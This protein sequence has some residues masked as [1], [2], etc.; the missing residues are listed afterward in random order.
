[1]RAERPQAMKLSVI[2]LLICTSTIVHAA[3]KLPL[4]D[5]LRDV[6]NQLRN[7]GQQTDDGSM[8]VIIKNIHVDMH[9]IA[10]KNQ[11]GQTLY[12]VLEGMQDK[13]NVITQKI[14]FDLELR[15][16]Y[17]AAN[18]DKRY[19][20]YS[21]RKKDYR[22]GPDNYRPARPYPYRPEHYLPDLYP[23]ILY[24]KEQ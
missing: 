4:G 6:R 16:D 24:G 13:S 18:N 3:D 12:Y 23:V 19:R 17:S 8:P 21:T 5:F 15:H 11:Q 14:S 22:Y 7:I 20:T 2:F 9:V 10:E 1:M